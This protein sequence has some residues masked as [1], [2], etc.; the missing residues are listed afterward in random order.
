MDWCTKGSPIVE[1]YIKPRISQISGA[2]HQSQS[3]DGTDPV[4]V[5]DSKLAS[6]AKEMHDQFADHLESH[7]MRCMVAP[8]DVA[9]VNLSC[10]NDI[11]VRVLGINEEASEADAG[12]GQPFKF[13]YW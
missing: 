9:T 5:E 8:R 1:G 6:H 11:D 10:L 3:L 2:A 13:Y 7:G 12:G 4:P